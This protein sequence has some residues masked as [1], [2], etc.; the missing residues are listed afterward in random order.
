[1]EVSVTDSVAV[2]VGVSV[3]VCVRVARPVRVHVLVGAGVAP[4]GGVWVRVQVSVDETGLPGVSEATGVRVPSVPGV[5]VGDPVTV[6]VPE[7]SVGK[8]DGVRG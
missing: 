2:S 5:R 1:V 6:S 7:E 8:G 3:K 4:G